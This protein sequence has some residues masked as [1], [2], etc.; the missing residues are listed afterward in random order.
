[1]KILFYSRGFEQVGIE[2]LSAVLK[3]AG[4]QVELVFDPGFDDN[5]YIQLAVLKKLNREDRMIRKACAFAPDLIGFS[6]LTNLYPYVS[7]MAATLKRETG[8]TVLAG[9][10]HPSAL[11]EYVL[12]DENVDMV[13]VGEGEDALLELTGRM[14][15]GESLLDTR[16]FWF[17]EHGK[18][19]ENPVRPLHENLDDLPLPDRGLYADTGV[20]RRAFMVITSRGCPFNCTYCTHA[21]QRTLYKEHGYPV[22]RRSVPGVMEELLNY[23]K[24]YDA[25]FIFFEDDD[26][27]SNI[28]WL[29]EFSERYRREIALPFYCLTNPAQT[30][31]RKVRILKEAGCH[32]LFMGIDSG[33]ETLRRER[34]NRKFTNQELIDAARRIQ[35]AGIQLRCTAMFAIPDETPQDMLETI[36]LVTR[37]RP[38]LVSTYTFYP[39]PRT[40]LFDYAL[41]K[42]YIDEEIRQ[43][44]YRGK[45]SIHG[46][47]ILKIPHK[48]LARVFAHVLPLLNRVPR[49]WQPTLLRFFRHEKLYHIS[50][51]FY[52]LFIP[53]TYPSIGML[54]IKDMLYFIWKSIRPLP[55]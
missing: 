53:I 47:S 33:S 23:K 16:N 3:R 40:K 49:S 41:E 8:A 22:R 28:Q 18:I 38:Q 1:M 26:F 50:F 39:Y 27:A 14:E 54:R 48:K 17:K 20:F 31:E 19:V 24:K 32:E 43:Q 35:G 30:S 55:K 36:D 11:P 42:G 6:C 37:I 5:T 4:H 12:Q 46:V 2:Y 10:P 15:R 29:E 21:F 51:L 13:C 7:R 25:R 34:L 44:I 9:G 52:Y 45:S